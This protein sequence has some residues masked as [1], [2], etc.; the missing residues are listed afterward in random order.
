MARLRRHERAV[1]LD[2]A[3][4]PAFAKLQTGG[5]Q[6]VHEITA[7]Q[8]ATAPLCGTTALA[9]IT[10]ASPTI[11]AAM[12]GTISKGQPRPASPLARRPLP[13]PN[14]GV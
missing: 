14:A 10:A 4:V 3:V 13:S 9:W 7:V 11:L 5:L 6:R 8:P 12:C 1:A 2:L